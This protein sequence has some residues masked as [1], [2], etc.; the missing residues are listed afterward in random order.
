MACEEAISALESSLAEA[1][2][3]IIL[4]ALAA[5]MYREAEAL[6]LTRLSFASERALEL[7]AEAL[8]L[9]VCATSDI[10]ALEAKARRSL[11]LERAREAALLRSTIRGSAKATEVAELADRLMSRG[12]D[13]EL[14][15]ELLRRAGDSIAPQA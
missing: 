11:E 6:V 9:G 8:A 1:R 14:A 5:V 4:V 12:D 7:I 13:D 3:P 2:S 10:L 15:A